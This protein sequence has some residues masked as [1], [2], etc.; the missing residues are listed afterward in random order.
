M[1]DNCLPSLCMQK[2]EHQREVPQQKSGQLTQKTKNRRTIKIQCMQW[3]FFLPEILDYRVYADA[4][5]QEL[6]V[7]PYRLYPHEGFI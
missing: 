6:Q 1:N 4:Y 2:P 3:E 7:D 5:P